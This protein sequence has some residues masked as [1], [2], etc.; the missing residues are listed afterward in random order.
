M[1]QGI[2]RAS[3]TSATKGRLWNVWA[4]CLM[5]TWS[6]KTNRR[7]TPST[8]AFFASV[9]TGETS[10]QQSQVHET[11]VKVQGTIYIDP[12]GAGSSLGTLEQ[13]ECTQGPGGM[14]SKVL[15]ELSNLSG[16][17][18][19]VSLKRHRHHGRVLGT[20][21]NQMPL[22]SWRRARRKI[23]GTTG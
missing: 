18:L 5:G 1:W 19:T 9:F 4:Y 16:R 8:S 21:A 20:W 11:S 22:L 13:T 14:D 12:G 3:G 17:P 2:W 6:Q 10:L 23:H 15:R 7:Q